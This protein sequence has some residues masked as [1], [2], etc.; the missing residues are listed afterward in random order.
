MEILRSTFRH[1][2]PRERIVRALVLSLLFAGFAVC[3]LCATDSFPNLP[4]RGVTARQAAW[5]AWIF[6]DFGLLFI[7]FFVVDALR[8][9]QL[10]VRHLGRQA[11][12][13]PE[14]QLC[15]AEKTHWARIRQAL[16]PPAGQ[17]SGSQG[18]IVDG[19]SEQKVVREI[20][21]YTDILNKLIWYPF[22]VMLLG[23]V[24]GQRAFCGWGHPLSLILLQLVL[25]AALY[26]HTW[27]L[28]I[29]A[30]DARETILRKL[31]DEC[32]ALPAAESARREHLEGVIKDIEQV[33]SGA[34]SHWTQ[35]Y[36]VKAMSLPFLGEGGILL[37]DRVLRSM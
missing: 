10:F 7:T 19:L 1:G 23:V 6:G 9:G 22:I 18:E 25:L 21:K 31:R 32:R 14:D 36:F 24:A 2:R 26:F 28:R 29:E 8:L 33:Q 35:D 16:G 13:W 20:A 11:G 4:A 17:R 37:L 30:D 34:Y 3:L 27:R 15:E 5:L 12:S